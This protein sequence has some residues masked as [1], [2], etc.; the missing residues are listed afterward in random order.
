[1][2][3]ARELTASEHPNGTRSFVGLTPALLEEMGE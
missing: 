3:E 2:D 1:L